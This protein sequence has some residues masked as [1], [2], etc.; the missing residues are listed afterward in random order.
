MTSHPAN[1]QALIAEIEALLGKSAPRLPW[2]VSGEASQQRRVLE[3]ALAYLKAASTAGMDTLPPDRAIAPLSATNAELTSQQV[4]QG[5][6]EEM[7]YLRSQLIGPLTEEVISLQQQREALKNEVR[8]LEM[9]RLNLMSASPSGALPTAAQAELAEQLRVVI[10]DEL[11]P[12][13][14]SLQVQI[15]NA[16]LLG[17]LPPDAAALNANLPQL[18][19][20][21]RL[22]QLQQIQ[23]QTDDMLLRLDSNLRSI[24]ESLDQSIQSYCDT[25]NQGLDAMHSLGQQGEVIFRAFINHLAQQLM[26]ESEAMLQ[27]EAGR[28]RL[29][30][31]DRALDQGTP[32]TVEADYP[33]DSVSVDLGDVDLGD[34]DWDADIDLPEEVTLFQ[35]DDDLSS[36]EDEDRTV[37]QQGSFGEFSPVDALSDLENVLEDDDLNELDEWEDDALDP[38]DLEAGGGDR[39]LVQRE[40]VAWSS[41]ITQ[42]EKDRTSE[43]NPAAINATADATA[44]YVEEIDALQEV[45]FGSGGGEP[46]AESAEVEGLTADPADFFAHDS[47]EAALESTGGLAS[48]AASRPWQTP[49]EPASQEEPELDTD[50]DLELEAIPE[51]SDGVGMDFDDLFATGEDGSDSE[52]GADS[53]E[54]DS[55][56]TAASGEGATPLVDLL[57]EAGSQ[58]FAPP[59]QSSLEIDTIS[60]LAELLPDA[61]SLTARRADPFALFEESEDVFIPAPPDEDLLISDASALEEERVEFTL[62]DELY[63]QLSTDLSQLEGL[64]PDAGEETLHAQVEDLEGALP[65]PPIEVVPPVDLPEIPQPS[66]G[67]IIPEDT[68]AAEEIPEEGLSELAPLPDG[69]AVPDEV[70]PAPAE[71]DWDAV[72]MGFAATDER[73]ALKTTQSEIME[74]SELSPSDSVAESLPDWEEEPNPAAEVDALN[75]LQAAPASPEQTIGRDDDAIADRFE[76]GEGDRFPQDNATTETSLYSIPDAAIGEPAS[77]QTGWEVPP[78]ERAA[79]AAAAVPNPLGSEQPF[80]I[81]P[82]GELVLEENA[83]LPLALEEYP[84]ETTPALEREGAIAPPLPPDSSDALPELTL[85]DDWFAESSSAPP[86]PPPESFPILA[87]VEDAPLPSDLLFTDRA[88]T[89]PFPDAETAAE[90]SFETDFLGELPT[91]E[92]TEVDNDLTLNTILEALESSP[93][94]AE[95]PPPATGVQEMPPPPPAELSFEADFLGELPT[96]DLPTAI[97]PTEADLSLD[98][99][100]EAIDEAIA[101]DRSAPQPA[102]ASLDGSDTLSLA[103]DTATIATED[104]S[105]DSFA[106][107]LERLPD[108]APTQATSVPSQGENTDVFSLEALSAVLEDPLSD[109]EIEVVAPVQEDWLGALGGEEGLEP[110]AASASELTLEGLNLTLS[111]DFKEASLESASP[112]D[113]TAEDLFSDLDADFDLLPS[114]PFA[115]AAPPSQ[116]EDIVA[117]STARSDEVIPTFEEWELEESDPAPIPPS[118]TVDATLGEEESAKPPTLATI[119]LAGSPE[120]GYTVVMEPSLEELDRLLAAISSL[121]EV[122]MAPRPDPTRRTASEF[123][124]APPPPDAEVPPPSAIAELLPPALELQGTYESGFSLAPEDPESSGDPTMD[125]LFADVPA[126]V[127]EET[128]LD[129]DFRP[130]SETAPSLSNPDPEDSDRADLISL[131]DLGF[132]DNAPLTLPNLPETWPPPSLEPQTDPEAISDISPDSVAGL[133][134]V[135]SEQTGY[136]PL[137][138]PTADAQLQAALKDIPVADSSLPLDSPGAGFIGFPPAEPVVET[139]ALVLLEPPTLEITGSYETGFQVAETDPADLEPLEQVIAALS[140]V[141]D[142]D[143]DPGYWQ[144]EADLPPFEDR[145]AE[146]FA[147][148]DVAMSTVEDADETVPPDSA[149]LSATEL[150]DLFP[151]ADPAP[152]PPQVIQA[153]DFAPKA[154][155]A[156]SPPEVDQPSAELFSDEEFADLFPP[157]LSDRAPVVGEN[158]DLPVDLADLPE[159]PSED[160]SSDD[161]TA[162]ADWDPLEADFPSD[163]PSASLDLPGWEDE[164]LADPLATALPDL[165][166]DAS[167]KT[168]GE[169][170]AMADPAAAELASNEPFPAAFTTE[171]ERDRPEAEDLELGLEKLTEL[172][173]Q[174]SDE[175][176]TTDLQVADFSPDLTDQAPDAPTNRQPD[177]PLP[178]TSELAEA[179]AIAP[180]PLATTAESSLAP[181]EVLPTDPTEPQVA[182][183]FPGS[184]SEWFLGIDLGTTGLSAVL[185]N[186]ATGAAHPLYWSHTTATGQEQATFRLPLVATLAA[187]DQGHSTGSISSLSFAALEQPSDRADGHLLHTLKPFLKT[188]IPHATPAGTEEPLLQVRPA[189]TLPLATVLDVLA[190]LLRWVKN[191]SDT[192]VTVDAVGLEA[193]PLHDI[194]DALQGVIVGHP[195]NW[196]DTYRFNVREVILAA[197]LVETAS[198]V[199]FV[200]E[201]IAAILSGLPDPSAPPSPPNRQTQT[202]YQCNWQGGTVVISGGASCTELGLVNLPHPLDTLSREDFFLR[203]LAYGG[204]AL[205]LD[206]LCQLLVPPERRQ[207]IAPSD[208]RSPKAQGWSW[209]ATLPEVQNARWEDLQLNTL[210]L[211]Q[212]ADPDLASR[213]RLRYHL[214]ASPLGRSLLEAARYLKLVL[215]QQNQCQ[216]ELADQSWRVLRR[217]FENRVLV[218]YV[219]RLNQ[220]L[221]A[222]LSQ[223]GL[224]PQAVNQVVCTG[225]NVSFSAIAKWLREKFPNATIIQDTYPTNRP[226]SCSRVAYGLVNLCRYPQVLDV[227]RH[228][229]SDYFLLHEMVQ[230]LPETPLP[231]EG[232][233]HLLEAHGINTDACRGRIEA[234]LEGHLPPGL[235]PDIHTRP[236]LSRATQN[237]EA[238]QDLVRNPLF[239]QQTRQIYTLNAPQRDRLRVHLETLLENKHQSLAEPLIAQL[240][241]PWF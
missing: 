130:S 13:F 103:D 201:A 125:D 167:P 10:L 21:Q 176:P 214:E 46:E 141:P 97:A 63:S 165:D 114:D 84:P 191:P 3:E 25:L 62:N 78:F 139:P 4:L 115:S 233:L 117:A 171:P 82:D 140:D 20:Q 156:S 213:M 218:P 77:P 221:N 192:T 215:Q 94:Q 208:R 211:P 131:A 39:T 101:P 91:P 219:Q 33:V 15:G 7:Q 184:E 126:A 60:S 118:A 147:T 153:E 23:A 152:V 132:P 160:I 175:S 87:T 8:Q 227:S 203:N 44:S 26:Q 66:G 222:L 129:Q 90:L 22:A 27:A 96:P 31:R 37:F 136:R 53:V 79:D 38:L 109:S 105:L 30:S 159:V 102:P 155:A 169:E 47:L 64:S 207:P 58:A 113:T 107:A 226:L 145:M 234:I 166:G 5:V 50:S 56:R 180:A 28:G 198:Q 196:S 168:D 69:L 183:G 12:Y 190:N 173:Q 194:L 76:E 110:D 230:T 202:L 209:R 65:T 189:E 29:S 170:W 163:V 120:D 149:P 206:I 45:L 57:G 134:L 138:D 142:S 239:T 197:G 43:T 124:F 199:F 11:V 74:F 95:V 71:V 205:D 34:V 52:A 182:D 200:E 112:A 2:A 228:Q 220:H 6:L 86:L 128:I 17:E 241:T 185:M 162:Q 235:V 154:I 212:L 1:L 67:E 99:F 238:Y 75:L 106:N 237:R 104:L 229:Y 232:I 85:E 224:S 223:T 61:D 111:L 204:D 80:E 68:R 49:E 187:S 174:L 123:G 181:Q 144:P 24:F 55:D 157:M 146:D 119:D 216:L 217:D 240:V 179:S 186:P 116:G 48:G 236:Y 158:P 35:V 54:S 100:A 133:E 59:E 161:P 14:R 178:A 98:A 9:T 81:L 32:D 40:P 18:T 92:A 122:P 88:V 135:G 70:I 16:P 89:S 164:R 121:E 19:P 195:S 172:V 51:Y 177:S 127:P 83:D 137:V 41:L 93:A 151:I 225:G 108:A 72:A 73:P 148:A 36:L 231:L 193:S 42:L 143:T 210:D 188:G 150:A